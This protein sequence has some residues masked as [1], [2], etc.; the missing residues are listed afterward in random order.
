LSEGMWAEALH[1]TEVAGELA[2]LWAVVSS[3]VEFV[4]G[5]SPNETF[6]VEVMDEMVAKFQRMGSY[7]CGLSVLAHGSVTCSLAR[8]S[9]RPN[10][11][12]V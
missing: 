8:H 6:W 11:P 2:V 1:H 3:T 7:P 12:T 9:V 10:E 4:L 5:R